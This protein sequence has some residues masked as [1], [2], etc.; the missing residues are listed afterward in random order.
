MK[1]VSSLHFQ[2][3][4]STDADRGNAIEPK[5]GGR[6][7]ITRFF[8]ERS[9]NFLANQNTGIPLKLSLITIPGMSDL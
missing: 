8:Y 3:Q 2:A 5:R 1:N 4:A 6:G 7:K 9:R